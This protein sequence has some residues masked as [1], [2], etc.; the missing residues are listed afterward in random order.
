MPPERFAVLQALLAHLLVRCGEG[1]RAVIPADELT[2]GFRI[3]YEQL[4]DHLQLLN[5]VNFG[6]GCYAVYAVLDGDVVRV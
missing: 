4:D 3:P 6:G 5:L 1:K 2:E